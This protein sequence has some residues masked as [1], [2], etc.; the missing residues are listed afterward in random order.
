MIDWPACST[1][2]NPIENIGGI[3][4]WRVYAQ[5]RQYKDVFEL[6]EANIN[7]WREF[8]EDMRTKLV[9]SMAARVFQLIYNKG[10]PTH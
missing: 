8:S 7:E 5:K 2:Q 10:D 4:A 3:L 1:D 6:K 9:Q